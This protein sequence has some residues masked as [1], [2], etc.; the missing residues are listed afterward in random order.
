MDA[1]AIVKNEFKDILLVLVGNGDNITSY[2]KYAKKISIDKNIIIAN[3]VNNRD[4]PKYYAGSNITVLPSYSNS[5]GFGMVLLEAGACGKP[6]I[7]T[8]VGGIP[9]A[10]VDQLTGLLVAPKDSESLANAMIRIL[11]DPLLAAYM[12]KA[13]NKRVND[14]FTW[15]IQVHKTHNLLKKLI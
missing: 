6:V 3:A 10:I 1:I 12:S 15:N 11:K 14:K 8:K 4:L 13:G 7:G 5:E 9:Y 2:F